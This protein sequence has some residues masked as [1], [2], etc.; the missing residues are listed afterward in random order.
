[1]ENSCV[2][3]VKPT[4]LVTRITGVPAG[5]V[6]AMWNTAEIDVFESA[7]MSEK[8]SPFQVVESVAPERLVPVKV[9]GP[10]QPCAPLAGFTAV[11]EGDVSLT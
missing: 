5:A 1:M 8:L 4:G 3:V 9:T 7:V 2:S 6:F 10:V 11:T